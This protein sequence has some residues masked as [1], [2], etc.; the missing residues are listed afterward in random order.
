MQAPLVCYLKPFSIFGHPPTCLE[1]SLRVLVKYIATNTKVIT[2][3]MLSKYKPFKDGFKHFLHASTI[4]SR[5]PKPKNETQIRATNSMRYIPASTPPWC[6]QPVPRAICSTSSAWR[7][8]FRTS[9]TEIPRDGSGGRPTFRLWQARGRHRR[10]TFRRLLYNKRTSDVLAAK[11]VFPFN[12]CNSKWY[13]APFLSRKL[14]CQKES[15]VGVS[16]PTHAHFPDP[17]VCL[18]VRVS[19]IF[20]KALIRAL[21]GVWSSIRSD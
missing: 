21:F 17:A 3:D 14:H 9:C 20:F 2:H 16:R 11:R 8:P 1:Y 6:R 18:S 19:F 13:D 15:T 7:T 10:W 12:I 5:K 4:V